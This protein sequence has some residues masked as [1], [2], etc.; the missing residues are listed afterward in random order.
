MTEISELLKKAEELLFQENYDF[1]FKFFK[2]IIEV[3]TGLEYLDWSE[4]KDKSK[5]PSI[6]VL[7]MFGVACLQ[8]NEPNLAKEIFKKIINDFDVYNVNNL[9]SLAQLEEGVEALNLYKKAITLLE[10]EE[11]N[12]FKKDQL[13]SVYCSIVELFMSDLCFE[14]DA[15]TQCEEYLVK[16]ET[17]TPNS[18][19]VSQLF[20]SFFI[21]K[22]NE[23][24]AIEFIQK[25]IELMKTVNNDI[26]EEDSFVPFEFR[27]QTA[28]L[29]IE[30]KKYLD[31]VEL[32]VSL[33]N[34]NDTI[35]ESWILL[36]KC[37]SQLDQKP[38]AQK[39]LDNA[40]ELLEIYLKKEEFKQNPIFL[41]QLE[42]VKQLSTFT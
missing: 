31:A 36:G 8:G 26:F 10:V 7:E 38:H 41:E 24:K 17:L 1:C 14:E 35:V 3:S 22:K 27:I 29:L 12:T 28:R 9:L 15:E 42:R 18:F 16:A 21:S 30:L 5:N 32:L 23:E 40:K 39:S 11:D 20:C 25:T 4:C 34:E 6:D 2:R 33:V 37:Y 19:E 13:S